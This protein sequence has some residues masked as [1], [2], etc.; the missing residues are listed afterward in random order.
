MT[1]SAF[2]NRSSGHSPAQ[3]ATAGIVPLRRQLLQF[4]PS[5]PYEFEE[6]ARHRSC[7]ECS[8]GH[9]SGH[10]DLDPIGAEEL[11]DIARGI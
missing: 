11:T 4:A 2:V 3:P 8:S 6:H 10:P 7:F 5:R 1:A 9:R